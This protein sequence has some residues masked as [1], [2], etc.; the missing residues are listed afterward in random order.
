MY[1]ATQA[2]YL[3]TRMHLPTPNMERLTPA[4]ALTQGEGEF[5]KNITQQGQHEKHPALAYF[6]RPRTE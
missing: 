6:R 3:F 5:D 1:N 4:S 2:R